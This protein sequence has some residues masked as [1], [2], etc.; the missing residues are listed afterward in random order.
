MKNAVFS[1][2]GAA[3][4]LPKHCVCS[5]FGK[6]DGVFSRV[7]DVSDFEM[8]LL[9]CVSGD[10]PKSE[11][12]AQNHVFLRVAGSKITFPNALNKEQFFV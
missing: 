5:R 12:N 6:S 1:R 11:K 10:F 8:S 7:F 2:A 4:G 3:Q 9:S